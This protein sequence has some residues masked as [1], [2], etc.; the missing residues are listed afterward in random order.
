MK[1]KTTVVRL[2]PAALAL[3]LTVGAC[4]QPTPVRGLADDAAAYRGT[5]TESPDIS[6]LEIGDET[7]RCRTHYAPYVHSASG[8]LHPRHRLVGVGPVRCDDGT[9]GDAIV[10][11]EESWRGT[12]YLTLSDGRLIVLAFG[13][14]SLPRAP[15]WARLKQDARTWQYETRDRVDYCGAAPETPRCSGI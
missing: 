8:G 11:S 3:A 7:R 13:N 5:L 1:R 14:A 12:G 15:D 4:G 9:V 6:V 2:S 10:I